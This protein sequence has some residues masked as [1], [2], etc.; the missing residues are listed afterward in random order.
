MKTSR[1]NLKRKQTQ[2]TLLGLGVELSGGASDE[3]VQGPVFHGQHGKAKK[4]TK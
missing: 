3:Q 1:Y 2:Q 4:N